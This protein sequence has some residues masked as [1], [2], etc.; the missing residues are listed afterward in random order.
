MN[1]DEFADL[2]HAAVLL[3]ALRA[4]D[5][6]SA[7]EQ[8]ERCVAA[9]LPVVELTTTTPDWVDAL[10]EVRAA[11]PDLV[12]GVGTVLEPEQAEAATAS[13]AA[14]LVSPC[15]VP[16][17]RQGI[18][19]PL[20][21]GGFTPGELLDSTSRGIGKLFPAHVG[22]PQ[23]LRSIL[24]LRPGARIVPTGGI[25][26]DAVPQWLEAGALA[27]GI[28]TGLFTVPDLAAQ[29]RSLASSRRVANQNAAAPTA[30]R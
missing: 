24:A 30:T 8:V 15:P 5:R 18:S 19:R 22:G 13:G 27:V 12:V 2:L 16:A 26:L 10:R 28:G 3:P 11:W 17:V 4:P 6:T 1:V 7:L 9:Q 21:E 14:F 29:V 23:M 25:T 20:I